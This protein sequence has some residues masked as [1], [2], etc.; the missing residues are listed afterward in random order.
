MRL[1]VCK[2]N[3]PT[4]PIILLYVGV[5]VLYN[6]FYYFIFCSIHETVFGLDLLI[7]YLFQLVQIVEVFQ[8]PAWAKVT[9]AFS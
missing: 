3:V 6:H 9:L 1:S 2:K 8:D 4:L 7:S 5:I